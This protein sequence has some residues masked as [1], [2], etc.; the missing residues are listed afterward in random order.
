MTTPS[1]SKSRLSYDRLPIR[2]PFGTSDHFFF[3]FLGNYVDI[4]VFSNMVRP[5]SWEVESVIYGCCWDSPALSWV[6]VPWNSW[7]YYTVSACR[8]PHLEGQFPVFVTPGIR[9]HSSTYGHL[10]WFT[11]YYLL[12]SNM[13]YWNRS[14]YNGISFTLTVICMT[15]DKFNP[16][17]FSVLDL[18]MSNI[19]N[20]RI[21]MLLNVLCLLS[22]PFGYIIVYVL[23]FKS[24]MCISNRGIPSKFSYGAEN[25]VLRSLQ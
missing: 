25:L 23:N 12:Q 19:L 20:I 16:L 18:V 3:H 24:I 22:V 15:A 2:L 7:P 4:C 5:L 11:C 1:K 10:V 6:R 13:S 8:L 21:F 9:E 14:Y 17:Q